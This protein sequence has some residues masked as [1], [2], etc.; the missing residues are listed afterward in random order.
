MA[1]KHWIQTAIEH[2]GALHK[3]LGVP[4]GETIPMHMLEDAKKK[5][6]VEG[7]EAQLAMTLE[8][9]RHHDA[10]HETQHMDPLHS[11]MGG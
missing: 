9:L 3:R 4:E 10:M 11:M 7:H 1:E 5:G 8:H 2:K 6:G